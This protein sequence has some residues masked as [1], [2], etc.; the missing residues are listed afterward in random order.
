MSV[1][2]E[3]F[4]DKPLD[5]AQVARR[6]GATPSGRPAPTGY[7]P[8]VRGQLQYPITIGPVF[9]ELYRPAVVGANDPGEKI[10][11]HPWLDVTQTWTP[12]E[13]T[14]RPSGVQDPLTDGPA[15]PPIRDLSLHYRRE[16]G[17]SV[18]AYYNAPGHDHF[19]KN[20]NQDG[21]SWTFYQDPTRALMPYDPAQ[22]TG[23]Q[24][25]D[26]LRAIPPSPAHGWA[27]RPLVNAQAAIN[28][29]TAALVQE[30]PPKQERLANSTYAGQTYG[31]TTA[32]AGQMDAVH[33]TPHSRRG[34]G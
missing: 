19:P 31:Q 14:V 23:G 22:T 2:T 3:E 7:Y 5:M 16:S 30:Q 27:V 20:G 17:T 33:G 1:D 18:T 26:T 8:N 29:K 25:P 9:D 34:R 32:R 21:A 4:Y 10:D 13:N 15:Q 12:P 11:Q 28:A 6:T 24:M